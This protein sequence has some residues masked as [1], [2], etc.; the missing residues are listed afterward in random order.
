[1]D[2]A[3]WRRVEE[4]FH[5][6][7]ELDD[8]ARE[9][10]LDAECGDDAEIRAAVERLA[11]ADRGPEPWVDRFSLEAGVVDPWVDRVLGHY[12]IAER[13]AEG[14]MGIVYRA[15]RADGLFERP[16]AVKLLRTEVA[17][18][19]ALRRFALERRTL[20][21][22]SHPNVARLVDGGTTDHGAPY[23]VMEYVDGVSIARHCAERRLSLE[24]RLRLFVTVCRA[25]HYA[26]QNLVVHRDLKPSNV[27]VDLN[28]NPKLLDFGIARLLDAGGDDVTRTVTMARVLTPEYASPEQLRGDPITTATDIYSLGVM[29]Y[30]LV[31][32]RA[33]FQADGRSPTEWSKMVSEATAPRPSTVAASRTRPLDGAE[34][35][36][37]VEFARC[38]RT[39]PKKLAS[40][41]R[42][43]LDRIVLMALRKEPGRRYASAEQLA[44]DLDRFLRGLPVIARDDTLSYRTMKFVRRNRLAVGSGVLIALALLGGI[45]STVRMARIAR[46]EAEHARVEAESF[47]E[48][49]NS[50]VDSF[51]GARLIRTDEQLEDARDAIQRQCDRVRRIHQDPHRRA[52][53][54][55]AFAKACVRLGLFEDAGVLIDEAYRIRVDTFGERSLEVALSLGS[56]GRLRFSEARYDE[57]VD[58][59]ERALELHEELP[60]GVHTEI[61]VALNDLACALRNAGRSDEAERYHERVLA[62]RRA[63][64]NQELAV[65]ES[66]NNLAGVHLDRRDYAAAA[67]DLEEAAEIR[68]RVL[69]DLDSYTLQSLSN[70]SIPVFHLGDQERAIDLLKRV[71]DGYRR[72]GAEG[73]EGLSHATS[74]LAGIY[75]TIGDGGRAEPLLID[76]IELDVRRLGRTHPRVMTHSRRLASAL[77]AEGRLD[78]AVEW[79]ARAVEALSSDENVRV[80]RLIDALVDHGRLLADAERFDEAGAVLREAIRRSADHPERRSQASSAL[81]EVLRAA[82][83]E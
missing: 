15:Y 23:L 58:A 18:H 70:L 4:L 10:F 62:L 12:R 35:A 31:V 75:L 17:T 52:N 7:V 83:V 56:I 16:V 68:S 13:I 28:G 5:R 49:A 27:L 2:P 82:S 50:F 24:E 59:F 73:E 71:A 64:G 30:E 55:D 69:G 9:A 77:R 6:S 60:H 3:T 39:S 8:D 43:D 1:M 44:D 33:P 26:H 38:C 74:N 78:E 14:G 54:L 45:V 42:G 25:V 40:E 47:R 46:H 36:R 20:A 61:E 66:L 76:A 81:E 67:E 11:D 79:M 19:D 21:A 48:F 53:L 41:L 29:L 32:G 57:A 63:A 80:E 22:L 51:L 72:L 37:I 65:A 34:R